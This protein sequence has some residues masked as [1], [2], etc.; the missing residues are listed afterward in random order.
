MTSL[1][2]SKNA[3]RVRAENERRRSTKEVSPTAIDVP[4]RVKHQLMR[5][6]KNMNLGNEIMFFGPKFLPANTVEVL[7]YGQVPHGAPESIRLWKA[8]FQLRHRRLAWS[9]T[10]SST[11]KYLKFGIGCGIKNRFRIDRLQLAMV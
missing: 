11:G 8:T 4:R 2:K 6:L 10:I 7:W 3:A 5:E 9:D 1:Y